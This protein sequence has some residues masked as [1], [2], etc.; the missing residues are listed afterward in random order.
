METPYECIGSECIFFHYCN[1]EDGCIL[2]CS[3]YYECVKD[4]EKIV[5]LVNLI[6]EKY[7]EEICEKW[8][9]YTL[10]SYTLTVS[11][12]LTSNLLQDTWKYTFIEDDI[13][14]IR[15]FLINNKDL[16]TKINNIWRIIDNI[17]QKL[18]KLSIK[19][20]YLD[21]FGL[22]EP[23]IKKEYFTLII[24]LLIQD[25][26]VNKYVTLWE[27]NYD[28][29]FDFLQYYKTDF[30]NVEENYIKDCFSR[31]ILTNCDTN[32]IIAI[33]YFLVKKDFFGKWW[34]YWQGA[35][36]N[37]CR[38]QSNIFGNRLLCDI[39][40]SQKDIIITSNKLDKN[41]IYIAGNEDLAKLLE[42]LNS[43]VGLYEVKKEVTSLINFLKIRKL[44]KE[45]GLKQIPI[46]LH[47]V[48]SGNPGTGKTTVARLL[49]KIYCQL[50]ILSKGH[51]IEV[52]RSGLVA[53]YVGQTA[54]KVKEV[55]QEALG[56]I[57]FIDEVYSLTVNRGESDFGFEAVDTLL[58]GMEDYRDDLIV[59]VAGYPDLMNDF[60]NSNPG[61]RSRFNKFI[62]F[63]DYTPQELLDIF[64]TMCESM[65]YTMSKECKNCVRTYFEQRYATKDI[66]FANGRDVRNYFEMAMVN[67][68]NRLST[69]SIIS[70]EI[71]SEL[72][73]EDVKDIII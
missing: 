73:L 9:L 14:E 24:Y 41:H 34:T 55:I 11:D 5:S 4:E 2:E 40:L 17:K 59:I 58:K 72:N 47:L 36:G 42:Q 20:E 57:L 61:L 22:I 25:K 6:I 70:D 50:G 52:D 27:Q 1:K 48:F 63:T 35:I 62:R 19:K 54:I 26:L 7:P 23:Q 31:G 66:N 69:L 21:D 16:Q 8:S 56:G 46:S 38:I 29:K 53:G 33:S 60:L 15:E 3:D 18:S 32:G 64:R 44:R 68:A 45:R 39:D 43:L 30:Q 71:L 51:L 13:K 28:N 12:K 67:Q 10:L 49:A 37:L 65:G